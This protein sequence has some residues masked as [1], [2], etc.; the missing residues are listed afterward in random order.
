MVALPYPVTKEYIMGRYKEMD[1]AFESLMEANPI[2]D[3]LANVIEDEH[4][5][6]RYDYLADSGV[7]ETSLLIVDSDLWRDFWEDLV[8]NFDKHFLDNGIAVNTYENDDFRLLS[9]SEQKM[10]CRR[11]SMAMIEMVKKELQMRIDLY[12]IGE[13]PMDMQ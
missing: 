1:I 9:E 3:P 8:E 10:V 2:I 7:D 11:F 4:F 13:N 12:A 5:E 6:L